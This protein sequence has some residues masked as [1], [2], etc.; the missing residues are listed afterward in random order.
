MVNKLETNNRDAAD[1]AGAVQKLQSS[2]VRDCWLLLAGLVGG[3][4]LRDDI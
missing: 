3:V 1:L 4:P 2:D